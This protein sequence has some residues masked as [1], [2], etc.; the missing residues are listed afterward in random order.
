VSR[1]LTLLSF[2]ILFAAP[3]AAAQPRQLTQLDGVYSCDLVECD[4]G[5]RCD[6]GASPMDATCRL[7]VG[8]APIC[9]YPNHMIEAYCCIEDSDCPGE[10]NCK[11]IEDQEFGVCVGPD[12][13]VRFCTDRLTLSDVDQCRDLPWVSY[14]WSHGDCDADGIYNQDEEGDEL[15]DGPG[16]C[17]GA[18]CD[19]MGDAGMPRPPHAPNPRA[20]FRGTGGCE[21]RSAP[22]ADQGGPLAVVLVAMML[23]TLCRRR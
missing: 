12:T 8:D 1:L 13:L 21:C 4:E 18:P 11:S 23:M 22:R 5:E 6:Y 16:W 3:T 19:E 7:L 2:A 10:T 9:N 17:D 15:C 20:N 14:D